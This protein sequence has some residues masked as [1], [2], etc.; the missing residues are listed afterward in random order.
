MITGL[1]FNE[2]YTL[3]IIIITLTSFIL[4]VIGVLILRLVLPILVERMGM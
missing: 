1:P 4:L 2:A 3:P